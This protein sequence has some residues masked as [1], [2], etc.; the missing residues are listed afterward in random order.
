MLEVF[1]GSKWQQAGLQ[2]VGRVWAACFKSVVQ[3]QA[4]LLCAGLLRFR[5]QGVVQVALPC[6]GTPFC[7][8]LI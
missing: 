1:T 4:A 8:C 5:L 6:A 7:G 2:G 3:I